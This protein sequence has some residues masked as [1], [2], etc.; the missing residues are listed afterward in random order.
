MELH[1]EGFLSPAVDDWVKRNQEK[2]HALF[3]HADRLRDLALDFAREIS[4]VASSKREVTLTTLLLR[5]I[6]SFEGVI[7]LSGRGMFVEARSIARNA[8]ET[9]FY[10]G[11]LVEDPSFIDKM[12]A[13]HAK[14]RKTLATELLNDKAHADV[15]GSDVLERLQRFLSDLDASGQELGKV[16]SEQAARQ[17]DMA[18][19]YSFFR[20]FSGDAHPTV[21]SLSRYTDGR[22]DVT[23]FLLQPD[24][25]CAHNALAHS[26][27]ALYACIMLLQPVFQAETTYSK[28]TDHFRWFASYGRKGE[29]DDGRAN[30]FQIG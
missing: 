1:G 26:I 3:A 16:V 7:L 29:Q 18:P 10:M 21:Q 9:A 11:A 20:D 30:D 14:H 23:G 12:I 15:I 13:D 17:S 28:V 27:P 6:S 5:A 25:E 19:L 8:L 24:D 4:Q 2:N 22:P